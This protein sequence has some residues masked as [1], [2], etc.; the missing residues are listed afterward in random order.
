VAAGA[1]APLALPNFRLL[2]IGSVL[3]NA[4]QWIQQVTLGWLVYDLT[5]SG[6]MLGSINL[7]RS[8]AT[9][10]L[11][12]AAGVAV[13]RFSRRTLMMAVNSWLFMLCLVF[14]LAVLV[15]RVEVWWLFLFTFLG[16]LAQAVNMP[17]R[18]TMIFS[19]VPRALAP[20]AVALIQTGWAV[21]RSLGPALGGFLILWFG[22]GG[23]F[24]VQAGAYALIAGTILRIR[25]P[26]Q[27]VEGGRP[28]GLATIFEGLRHVV[29][30]RQ[31]RAF[32]LMGFV[33]PLLI[34]PN[35]AAL[36]PIYA[37]DVFGGGPQVLGILMSAVGV[38]GIGGGFVTASLG[39]VERR[40]GV[41][42]A[43][44]LLTSLSLIG[45]ASSTTLTFALP[46]L[47]AAG[48]FEMIYLTTNQTLLQ[49][50][51][52]DSL[53]GRVMGIVALSSGLSPVGG[54]FAGA[55]ADLFGP[56]AV[57]KVMAGTAAVIAVLVF[58]VSSTIRDHRMSR[59]IGGGG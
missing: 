19:L 31:T 46:L 34:I 5:S 59:A 38:G 40:G 44:L 51:I 22:P 16:G 43:A 27:P 13:D 50:S 15:G 23:N 39:R 47:A 20:G 35:F 6:T 55:G 42:V 1:F 2:L 18:Q 8:V 21:M 56:R 28:S 14:G 12:P 36:P 49:L 58:F 24:L 32:A 53:R 33:L 25:F 7:V 10:G 37:K 54:F 41:M 30:E 9:V 3:S 57:T 17:L 29:A 4:G 26:R 52:P 45:F 48:F 11:A